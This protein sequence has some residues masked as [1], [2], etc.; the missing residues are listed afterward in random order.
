MRIAALDDLQGPDAGVG[1]HLRHLCTLIASVG[2]D[3]L[4][5]RKGSSCCAQQ[6][7]C[8]IA[9]L[10]VGWVDRDAQQQAERIDED[11]PF[12]ARDLFAR[13]ETLAG[14]AQSPFLSR[15]AA[16]TID[17]RDRGARLTPGSLARLDVERVVDAFQRAVPIP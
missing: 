16:L 15:L 7:T 13:V 11:V 12:A 3:A 10:N 2:K 9:I 8:A 1:D 6:V 17:D 14:R 5:E 4:D